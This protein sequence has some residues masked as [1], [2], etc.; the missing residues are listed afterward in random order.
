MSKIKN[1]SFKINTEAYIYKFLK[2]S[3]KQKPSFKHP[4]TYSFP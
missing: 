4:N 2:K 1:L 3:Q